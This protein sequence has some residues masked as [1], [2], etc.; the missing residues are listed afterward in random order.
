ME[1]GSQTEYGHPGNFPLTR[2]GDHSCE[3]IREHGPVV[4]CSFPCHREC[5][6]RLSLTCFLPYFRAWWRVWWVFQGDRMPFVQPT[7]LILVPF[8]PHAIPKKKIL[9]TGG[10][11]SLSSMTYLCG[12]F[13]TC[14]SMSMRSSS[15]RA[16]FS[17]RDSSESESEAEASN[18][19]EQMVELE[20]KGTHG[21]EEIIIRNTFFSWSEDK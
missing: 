17:T 8:I 7:L 21:V 19:E 11:I 1:T 5:Q 13:E 6:H 20:A 4:G 2:G 16:W 14:G 15:V 9:E 10:A 18:G 3:E 12:W